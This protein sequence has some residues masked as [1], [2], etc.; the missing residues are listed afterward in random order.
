MSKPTSQTLPP[1]GQFRP[2]Q[3]AE[4]ELTI[5]RTFVA[6]LKKDSAKLHNIAT[7]AGNVTSE[8]ALTNAHK[9]S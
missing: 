3:S 2:K 7:E 1:L 5:F 6:V 4:Q 9:G 8:D